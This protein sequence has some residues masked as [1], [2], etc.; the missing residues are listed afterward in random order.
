MQAKLAADAIPL[1]KKRN[2]WIRT[3]KKYK[4]MYALLFPALVYFAVFKYIPMAGI[5]I[6]F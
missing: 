2:S 4:V 5:I 6:A 3:I 1:T